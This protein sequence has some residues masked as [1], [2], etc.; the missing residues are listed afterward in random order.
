MACNSIPAAL[1]QPARSESDERPTAKPAKTKERNE[2]Q[3]PKLISRKENQ[4]SNGIWYLT[5]HPFIQKTALLNR[6]LR[7]LSLGNNG[8]AQPPIRTLQHKLLMSSC[9]QKVGDTP[10]QDE[11]PRNHKDIRKPITC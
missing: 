11:P 8:R 4:Y 3:C 9:L 5:T 2:R 7:S 10:Y 1:H 6:G